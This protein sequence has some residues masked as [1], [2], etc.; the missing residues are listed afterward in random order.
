MVD[1]VVIEIPFDNAFLPTSSVDSN[2]EFLYN[3]ELRLLQKLSPSHHSSP[4]FQ[5]KLFPS[6]VKAKHETHC[7]LGGK[8]VFIE[9]FHKNTRE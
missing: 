6:S 1:G 4:S 8:Y 2:P 9:S 7:E 5:L 3:Q